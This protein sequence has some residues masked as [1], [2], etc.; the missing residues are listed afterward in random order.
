M[1]DALGEIAKV[2]EKEG[3]SCECG[4]GH[5]EEH[6]DSG[7]DDE[8]P[9]CERCLACRIDP[10]LTQARREGDA[11]FEACV[12][13]WR[14]D[15]KPL[16]N[17][18]RIESHPAFLRIIGLGPIAVEWILN[19]LVRN[20]PCHLTAALRAITGANPTTPEMA[21]KLRAQAEAWIVWGMQN[22]YLWAPPDNDL[23]ELAS[24]LMSRFS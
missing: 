23:A 17:S 3:C 18:D 13:L 14:E 9:I 10:I 8:G 11:I 12:K 19:E 1:F 5:Y 22:G 15:T 4:H 6:N 20:G 7:P 21:G 24:K 2:L 16:S